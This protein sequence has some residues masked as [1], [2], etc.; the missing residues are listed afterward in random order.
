MDPINE[1]CVQQLKVYDGRTLVS[2][3]N[4]GLELLKSEDEKKFEDDKARKRIQ[5]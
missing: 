1:Y 4:E 3:T 2:V 5:K